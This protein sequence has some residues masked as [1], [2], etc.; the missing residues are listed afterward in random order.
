MRLRALRTDLAW[1]V[2]LTAAQQ[3]YLRYHRERR[4]GGEEAVGVVEET[5]S[6]APLSSRAKRLFP[7]EALR[8]HMAEPFESI[9]RTDPQR[10]SVTRRS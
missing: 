9:S 5:A 8:W 1:Q 7:Q 3:G 2:E 6:S 4:S 10:E